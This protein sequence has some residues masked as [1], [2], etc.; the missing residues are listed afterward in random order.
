MTFHGSGSPPWV[1]RVLL[2]M[3]IAVAA[4]GGGAVGAYTPVWG[5][6]RS[7]ATAA[8]H[9]A[10]PPQDRFQHSKH[11][12]LFPSCLTCH[13]GAVDAGQPMWPAPS[14][15]TSCHDGTAKPRVTWEPRTGPRAGNLRFAHAAHARAVMAT[16]PADSALTRNCAACH[17]ERGAPRMEVRN[18]VAGECLTCHGFQAPHVDLPSEACATC[19]VA[20]ADAPGLTPEDV[21]RFPTPR[22]HEA[23]AFL[24]GEHGRQAIGPGPPE[25]PR[26]VA[27]SCATCHAQNFCAACHVNA[28]EVP[29]IRALGVDARVPVFKASLPAPPSHASPAF[30]RSHGRDSQRATATCATCHT[31]ESC[32]TCH[33]G[34][35]P[36]AIASLPPAGAGR[37]PGVHTTRTPPPSH[38][39]EFVDRHGSEASARPKSCETC[40][41]RA[42]C[43][44]CHRPSAS[45]QS[46]SLRQPSGTQ[47]R[48][49]TRQAASAQQSRGR[50]SGYHPASFLTR[51]P[52]SA[53][54]RQANC[55]DCHNPAQFCQSCHQQSGLVATSRIG[56]AG[57]HDAFRGFSLG[58]GQAARQSLE[59]CA[60][61]HAERDCTACH[62]AVSGGFRFSPHG[63]G[64]NK[65]RARSKNPTLCIACHGNAIPRGR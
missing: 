40:H 27:A 46:E 26:A 41:V 50:K 59:S 62:S 37:A 60:S 35:A 13:G 17:N 32:L 48:E 8:P 42:Q 20:L 51:H 47:P 9:A 55:S 45:G 31:Q 3:A 44:D 19:H 61:C 52:S 28:P 36:R 7:V 54:A 14:Q 10:P 16:R 53:Y 11:A 2:P 18:A 22:S 1:V 30:L 12:R 4:V 5:A 29:Q 25:T 56:Q 58:H 33:V 64:F 65:E 63:P 43:L 49:G 34:T 23:P 6:S 39:R 57:Y 21:A 38:T 24:R 15:C